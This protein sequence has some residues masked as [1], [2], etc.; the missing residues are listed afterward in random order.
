MRPIRFR[1]WHKDEEL[2]LTVESINWTSK[3]VDEKG[4]EGIGFISHAEPIEYIEDTIQ[5]HHIKGQS[6]GSSLDDVILMQYTG[7]EDAKGVEIYEGDIA[8]NFIV[9]WF[10]LI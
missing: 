1:A 2:M 5:G 6:F 10:V 9:F 3:F 7:I 8:D 4:I